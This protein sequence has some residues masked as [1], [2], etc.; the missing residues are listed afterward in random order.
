MQVFTTF[1]ISLHCSIY[2]LIVLYF[3]C[4]DGLTDAIVKKFYC[5]IKYILYRRN[6]G[7]QMLVTAC[8]V[9]EL[10]SISLA[11]IAPTTVIHTPFVTNICRQWT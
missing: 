2:S 9:A 11:L 4:G 6:D 5:T 7:M 10:V 3:T 1:F 8:L